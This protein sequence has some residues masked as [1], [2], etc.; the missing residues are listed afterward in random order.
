MLALA[1]IDRLLFEE[2]IDG[3]PIAWL[4]DEIVLEVP[5]PQ[6]DR[7]VALLKKAMME[8]FAETFP[9]APLKDLVE[10]H[11]GTNWAAAKQ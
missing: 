9:G 8:A 6:V 2:G 10:P 4:H 11:I 5:A 1:A 7:A 3:D